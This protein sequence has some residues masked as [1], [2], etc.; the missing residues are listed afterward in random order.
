MD[1]IDYRMLDRLSVPEPYKTY[2]SIMGIDAFHK[3]T[4]QYGGQKIYIPKN[5]FLENMIRDENIKHE[6]NGSNISELARK[7]NIGRDRIYRILR[8]R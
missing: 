8:N 3:M 6:Y 7:Y 4:D 2:I 1:E 5:G